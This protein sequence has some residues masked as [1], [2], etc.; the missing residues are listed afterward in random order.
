[1]VYDELDN[2]TL[3]AVE[4]IPFLNETMAIVPFTAEDEILQQDGSLAGLLKS[5]LTL[6]D[7]STF[8]VSGYVAARG[9]VA[10]ASITRPFLRLLVPVQVSNSLIVASEGALKIGPGTLLRVRPG[11]IIKVGLQRYYSHLY[12]FHSH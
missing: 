11:V 2:P 9:N 1:M 3:E 4:V 10:L 8:V 5:A 7:N 12:R 6:P